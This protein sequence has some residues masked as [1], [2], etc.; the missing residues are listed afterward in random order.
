[1]YEQIKN[2]YEN[3][4]EDGRLFRDNAHQVEYLTTIKYFDSLFPPGSHILDACAGTG[5]YSFYL[6]DNG[7]FV[8]ACDLLK[9]NVNIIKA[10]PDAARLTD[11]AVCDVLDLSRFSDDSFDIV[12]C[13]GAL[14]HFPTNDLRKK[15]ILECVRVCKPDGLIVLAYITKVGAILARINENTS[16]M[17]ELV[18]ITSLNTRNGSLVQGVSTET[19][20]V[21]TDT[22][23][24]GPFF[25]AAPSEINEL[26]VTSGLEKIKH[27]GVDGLVYNLASNLNAAT[28]ENFQKYMKY[29]YATCEDE[30]IIGTSVHGLWVGRKAW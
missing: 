7:H 4:D 13:M 27:I 15:A 12:L 14:Y 22:E 18:R 8:T 11:I 2:Y 1:M 20:S 29:H 16:N 25:C 24:H 17:D 28:D 5:R 6:A 10:K 3:Y 23:E 9:Y 30:S 26:A 19:I 21:V